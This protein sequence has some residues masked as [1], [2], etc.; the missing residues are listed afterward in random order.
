MTAFSRSH[1]PACQ[2]LPARAVPPAAFS[3]RGKRAHPHVHPPLPAEAPPIRTSH[4]EGVHVIEVP[5]VEREDHV[6]NDFQNVCKA[7]IE[8]WGPQ[9]PWQSAATTTA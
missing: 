6:Q 7:A 9:R 3:R 4:V 8:A 5:I 2:C 1:V